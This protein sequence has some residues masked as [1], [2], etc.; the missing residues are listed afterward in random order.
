MRVLVIADDYDPETETPLAEMVSRH[1]LDAIITAGDLSQPALAGIDTLDVPAMGVYGNHCDGAYLATLGV[2]DLHLN[3]LQLQGI[4]FVGLQGC[5][6]YKEGC[7]D[8]L[9]TQDEYRTLVDALPPA[10]VL[11]THCPPRGIN[12]HADTAHVGIDALRGWMTTTAPAMI[13]HGHTYPQRP[14][15]EHHVIRIEYVYGAH[16]LN[17]PSPR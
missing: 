16:V 15:T 6:R 9:Y 17:I 12:D 7:D 2:T 1:H 13:I 10:D 4:S 14:V 11:V 5:V 3:R 8:I